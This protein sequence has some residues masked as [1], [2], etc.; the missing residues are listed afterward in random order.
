MYCRQ[1]YWHHWSVSH[2]DCHLAYAWLCPKLQVL[3][4]DEAVLYEP[5]E[6]YTNDMP[7]WCINGGPFDPFNHRVVQDNNTMLYYPS[8]ADDGKLFYSIDG[9]D[10]DTNAINSSSLTIYSSVGNITSKM[11][12][13]HVVEGMFFLI[14]LYFIQTTLIL[15]LVPYSYLLS[16]TSQSTE[17]TSNKYN[18]GKCSNCKL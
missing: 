14:C 6:D 8:L 13:L 4:A 17:W 12:L 2:T 15:L 11:I 3:V 10:C 16:S 9:S 7:F 5:S 1:Q 18:C